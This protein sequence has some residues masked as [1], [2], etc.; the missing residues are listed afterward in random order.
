MHVVFVTEI[1]DYGIYQLLKLIA[2]TQ[3]YNLENS[4]PECVFFVNLHFF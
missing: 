3:W 4:K 1:V 2:K